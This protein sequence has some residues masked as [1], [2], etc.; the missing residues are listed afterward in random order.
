MAA[1]IFVGVEERVGF[2]MKQQSMV[3]NAKTT[4]IFAIGMLFCWRCVIVVRARVNKLTKI[5]FESINQ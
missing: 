4:R 1:D 2:R 3:R 5:V